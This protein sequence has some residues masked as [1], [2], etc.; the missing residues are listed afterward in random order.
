MSSAIIVNPFNWK[1]VKQKIGDD[2]DDKIETLKVGELITVDSH[3][4][5]SGDWKTKVSGVEKPGNECHF[6]ITNDC[7]EP[8]ILC[9][10]DTTG[11][12][13]SHR[14]VN[15]KSI[16]DASVSNKHIEF[17]FSDQLFVC[18]K[19]TERFPKKLSE[20]AEDDF[21]CLFRTEAPQLKYNLKLC[22]KDGKKIPFFG[23]LKG[24][25]DFEITVEKMVEKSEIIRTAEKEYEFRCIYGF[26]VFYEDNVFRNI[27]EFEDILTLD[28]EY[29]TSLL[30]VPA[31]EK[32]KEN[33]PLWI[34]ES[35]TFGTKEKPI[36]GRAVTFHPKG[37]KNWLKNMGMNEDKEGGI[38]MY[39]ARDYLSSRGNWGPGG[40]LVHEFSHAFH[41]KFCKDGFNCEEI[42]QAYEVAM[43]KGLYDSVEVHGVQGKN[44]KTKAYACTNCMEF[45]AELSV[46][47]HWHKEDSTEYNKWFPF[48]RAIF[49]NHDPDSFSVIDKCWTQFT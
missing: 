9:W 40:V 44:G 26:K 22:S 4:F 34:N 46:C 48:N 36:K 37:G 7:Y 20:V 28:L 3:D 5:E 35:L 15:D 25:L 31:C 16:K 12:L 18:M 39:D 42:K 45:F 19:K 1:I 38:E 49:K 27:P 24:K 33:T 6:E 11:K 17:T 47:Y 32:L 29:V 43:K 2:D 23:R 21:I 8:I 30:P 13:H 10:V 14:P 41:N